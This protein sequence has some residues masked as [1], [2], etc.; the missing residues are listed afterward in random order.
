MP[1][2]P[3]NMAGV[4]ASA[5]ICT[6]LHRLLT[7]KELQPVKNGAIRCKKY[8]PSSF[9]LCAMAVREEVEEEEDDEAW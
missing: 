9:G 4:V 7:H 3:S 2:W 5:V 8:S 6:K 1:A